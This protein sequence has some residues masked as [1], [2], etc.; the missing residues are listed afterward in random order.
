[1]QIR[2]QT[3]KYVR[4]GWSRTG[5]PEIIINAGGRCGFRCTWYCNI[6][7]CWWAYRYRRWRWVELSNIHRQPL[8]DPDDT[9]RNKGDRSRQKNFCWM[10]RQTTVYSY[11]LTATNARTSSATMTWSSTPVTTSPRYLLNDACAAGQTLDIRSRFCHGRPAGCVEFSFG[12]Y[13]SLPV[14]PTPPEPV[15]FLIVDQRHSGHYPGTIGMLDGH[16]SP[17]DLAGLPGVMGNIAA[18]RHP[19]NASQVDASA[20]MRNTK[21]CAGNPGCNA[22]DRLSCFLRNQGWDLSFRR[23]SGH[24]KTGPIFSMSIPMNCRNPG[25]I[26]SDGR[27]MR[28]DPVSN[29]PELQGDVLVYCQTGGRTGSHQTIEAALSGYTFCFFAGRHQSLATVGKWING[30]AEHKGKQY[31]FRVLYRHSLLPT[32]SPDHSSKTDIGAQH[33][34]GTGAQR[35][36]EGKFIAGYWFTAHEEMAN[37]QFHRI[38]EDAF[39]NIRSPVCILPQPGFG[40]CR[41]QFVRVRFFHRTGAAIDAYNEIVERIKNEVPVGKGGAGRRGVCVEDQLVVGIGYW[42][43]RIGWMLK[44]LCGLN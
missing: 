37:R 24:Y 25:S 43:R 23:W 14:P 27:W 41:D 8:Y 19:N 3:N 31:L 16:G 9:G 15:L 12:S 17:E 18:G 7:R 5:P 10:V 22:S 33:F 4:M 13:L 28:S 35:R 30:M 40:S 39:E 36:E 6:G 2:Y 1:M 26:I 21:A 32:V 11:H 29:Q 42:D 34:S 20:G 38:R 44:Y